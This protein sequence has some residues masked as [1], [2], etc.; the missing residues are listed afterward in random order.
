MHYIRLLKPPKVSVEKPWAK[1]STLIT[2][3]TDLGDD[4]LAADIPIHAFLVKDGENFARPKEIVVAHA[5]SVWKSG[6]RVLQLS[7]PRVAPSALKDR[8]RLLV[9]ML[10][11][12]TRSSQ[13]PLGKLND[14][15]S[16]L[17]VWSCPF[18]LIHNETA[19]YVERQLA[20][21]KTVTLRVYEE[22]GE[23][24]ARHVWDAGIVLAALIHD[25]L[26]QRRI[27]DH[28]SP[29]A[30]VLR[31]PAGIKAVEL[32]SG[33]GIVG[34]QL[35][36]V[37]E[38]ATVLL[39][40]LPEAM[41]VLERNIGVAT[42]AS[43]SQVSKAVLD[44][45]ACVPEGIAQ[46]TF[47]LV[48]VSDCTYNSDSIPALVRTVSSLIERSPEALV[49]VA[50]KVRHESEA[51]FNEIISKVGLR[52]YNMYPFE[53]PDEQRK[54]SGQEFDNVLVYIYGPAGS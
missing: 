40:D 2:I 16:I 42:P 8:V 45:E 9:S 51:I 39:T 35:A 1:I 52:Q 12:D 27:S 13:I 44:W 11:G 34:L 5:K 4:F 3:T 37:R 20:V 23:S 24:I 49:V 50:M 28:N 19:S 6:S 30:R 15:P 54:A 18:D 17:P 26:L 31:K 29:F 46:Q 33:C 41:E 10:P 14:R 25:I 22:M 32:G 21:S 38:Q 53:I 43:G 36:H 48:L 47:D 7:I